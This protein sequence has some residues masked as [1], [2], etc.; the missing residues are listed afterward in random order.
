MRKL[1]ALAAVECLQ[2]GSVFRIELDMFI[3]EDDVYRLCKMRSDMPDYAKIDSKSFLKAVPDPTSILFFYVLPE[4]HRSKSRNTFELD[5][6]TNRRVST[7]SIGN[8]KTSINTSLRFDSTM[9]T[10]KPQ[11]PCV[12]NDTRNNGR[13]TR[14]I[15]NIT[16]NSKI[17]S[18]I[19]STIMKG[20]DNNA[21][22]KRV[23]VEISNIK[24]IATSLDPYKARAGVN[25]YQTKSRMRE[26]NSPK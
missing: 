24:G 20:N 1:K 15:D 6:K 2:P 23:S 21:T 12:K 10:L 22:K 4:A 8:L 18:H 7:N 19:R 26:L 3:T 16:S 17:N 13:S 25:L 14:Q 5:V 11:S 9:H